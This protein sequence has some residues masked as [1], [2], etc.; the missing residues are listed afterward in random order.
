MATAQKAAR[1][2]DI[3]GEALFTFAEKDIHDVL[4]VTKLGP[5]RKLWAR[6]QAGRVV[7][8]VVCRCS[9]RHPPHSVPVLATSSTAWCTGTRHVTHHMERV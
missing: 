4:Q 6:L 7:N 2:E 5:K 9:P 8:H 1:D 3:D